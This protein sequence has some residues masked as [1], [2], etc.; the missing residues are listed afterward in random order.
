M[1]HLHSF[2]TAMRAF[3]SRYLTELISHAMYVLI[4]LRSISPTQ[5]FVPPLLSSLAPIPLSDIHDGLAP[6]SSQSPFLRPHFHLHRFCPPF[7]IL[8]E[9]R[10]TAPPLLGH[11]RRGERRHRSGFGGPGHGIR[12]CRFA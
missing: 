7:A 2:E 12:R 8:P 1:F 10:P 6:I 3:V 4:R 9:T 11:D 5:F